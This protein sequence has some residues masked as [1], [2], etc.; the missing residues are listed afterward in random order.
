M[1]D[2]PE[3]NRK[4]AFRRAW[5]AVVMA[6]MSSI[7]CQYDPYTASYATQKPE[8]AVLIGTWTITADSLREL[9][10]RGA[11]ALRPQLIVLA[12]GR[13]RMEDIPNGWR[14]GVNGPGPQAETFEGRWTLEKHQ[15][16][17]GLDLEEAQWVCSGCLMVLQDRAPHLLVLRYGDPDEGIGIEFEGPSN[18]E[19]QR[20]SRR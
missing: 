1:L 13:V 8:R 10:R 16:W 12:D 6:A 20:T 9:G 11:G 7:A 18:N 14:S 4:I 17:W 19:M 3:E 2:G 15:D 5:L